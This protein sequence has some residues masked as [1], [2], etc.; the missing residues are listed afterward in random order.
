[1]EIFRKGDNL[2]IISQGSIKSALLHRTNKLKREQT[3]EEEVLSYWNDSHCK[4]FS[5]RVLFELYSLILT[6]SILSYGLFL[7]SLWILPLLQIWMSVKSKNRMANSEAP[8]EPSHQELH[9]LHRYLVWASELQGLSMA[10][11]ND[12]CLYWAHRQY[13]WK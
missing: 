9:C 1:M 4:F 11:Q 3:K 13:C 2:G 10:C 7:H 12:L 5:H 6:L 8:N